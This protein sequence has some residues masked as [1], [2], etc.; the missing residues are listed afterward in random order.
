MTP[1]PDSPPRPDPAT[2]AA[3][4]AELE[5]RYGQTR[6]VERALVRLIDRT[7]HAGK[8]GSIEEGLRDLGLGVIGWRVRERKRGGGTV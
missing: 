6:T 3:D 8:E 1:A 7:T 5:E 4:I 2:R